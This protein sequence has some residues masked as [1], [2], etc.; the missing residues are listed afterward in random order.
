MDGVPLGNPLMHHVLSVHTSPTH[1]C[2]SREPQVC[3]GQGRASEEER[4]RKPPGSCI[5]GSRCDVHSR[6]AQGHRRHTTARESRHP[7]TGRVS[8]GLMHRMG[9]GNQQSLLP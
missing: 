3:V 5:G 1:E 4:Q 8:D 6:T 9:F 7:W 2:H